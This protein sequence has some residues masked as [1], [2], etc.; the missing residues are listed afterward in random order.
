MIIVEKVKVLLK[1]C[2]GPLE[3]PMIYK[4]MMFPV[5]SVS[6]IM[7]NIRGEDTIR[8]TKWSS[9]Q[10]ALMW[11]VSMT[12]PSTCSLTEVLIMQD[13]GWSGLCVSV[14]W[15]HYSAMCKY[16]PCLHQNFDINVLKWQDDRKAMSSNHVLRL[17][18]LRLHLIKTLHFL[19]SIL[20]QSNNWRITDLCY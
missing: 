17:L 3:V 6:K 18:K 20:C 9:L 13:H 2:G 11:Q 16:H 19:T 15:M 14:W 5:P 12:V 1:I 4:M 7:W 10:S 8:E